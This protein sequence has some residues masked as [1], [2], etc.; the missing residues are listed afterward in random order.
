MNPD[1]TAAEVMENAIVKISEAMQQM[2]ST[3]LTQKAIVA[4]IHDRSRIPKA[5]I[6]SVLSNLED[7]EKVWLKKK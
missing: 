6:E 2:N 5:T 7:L 4:L 1:E 3:R